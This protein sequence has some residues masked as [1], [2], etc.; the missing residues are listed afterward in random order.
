M[1]KRII[2]TT[3]ASSPAGAYNQGV[4]AGGT[5]YTAGFGPRDPETGAIVGSDVQAQTRQVFANLRAVLAE[6]GMDLSNVVKTT[7]HLHDVVRDA[8]AFDETYAQLM[9]TPYPVRTTVGSVLSGM[10]VEIDVVA[11]TF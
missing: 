4:L 9:P 11:V 7:V 8:R 5:L 10:L 6:C 3:A 1:P 2:S